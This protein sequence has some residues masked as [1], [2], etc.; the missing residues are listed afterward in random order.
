MLRLKMRGEVRTG[1]ARKMSAVIG[2]MAPGFLMAGAAEAQTPGTVASGTQQK[3]TLQIEKSKIALAAPVTYDNKYEFYG[4]I[5]FMNFMAG[6]Q[7][8]EGIDKGGG[9]FFFY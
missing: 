9:G 5:N 3:P 2:I 6:G 8:P 4:S 1:S 7:P